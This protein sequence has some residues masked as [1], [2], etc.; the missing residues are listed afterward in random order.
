MLTSW[1]PV[2]LFRFSPKIWTV[3]VSSWLAS[4]SP[5]AGVPKGELSSIASPRWAALL[6]MR[7]V[8]SIWPD[9]ARSTTSSPASAS[10]R[11]T[12]PAVERTATSRP[13]VSVVADTLPPPV[14]S[15]PTS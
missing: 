7:L 15:R 9:G 1:P 12:L 10:Y 14:A 5:V 11:V 13:A 2:V 8:T 6:L 3:E 4:W